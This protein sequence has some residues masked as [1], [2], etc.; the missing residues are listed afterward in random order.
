MN[1]IAQI[2]YG[3]AL[4]LMCY[5]LL[6]A[7][8]TGNVAWIPVAGLGGLTAVA[9]R[10]GPLSVMPASE[11]TVFMLVA[12]VVGFLGQAGRVW[13]MIHQKNQN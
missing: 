4:I 1:I 9:I 5:G 7:I 2:G 11:D 8:A 10:F 12:V 3:A 6:S 13:A